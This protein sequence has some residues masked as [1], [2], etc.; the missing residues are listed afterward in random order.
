MTDVV[1]C[2]NFVLWTMKLNI[3]ADVDVLKVDE[4]D[5]DEIDADDD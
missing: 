3:V 5:E 4:N 2:A 1:S